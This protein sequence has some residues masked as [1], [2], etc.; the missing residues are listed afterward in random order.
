M[1]SN[2]CNYALRAVVY[3]AMKEKENVRTGIKQ[4]S[5]ELKIPSPFLGKIMQILAKNKILVSSKGPHGGFSLGRD[6]NDI[7]ILDIVKVIEGTEI[8][9]KC[10]IG[11]EVCKTDASHKDLCPFHK[12]SGPVRDSL[13][14]LFSQQSIGHLAEEL[15]KL[16]ENY[17]I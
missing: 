10:F 6:A 16:P 13:F 15:N 8:F 17:S 12:K 14:E 2:T 5:E 4:I 11:L 1:L 9:E 3:L 7:Y